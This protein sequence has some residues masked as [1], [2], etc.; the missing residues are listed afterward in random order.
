MYS[1]RNSETNDSEIYLVA[2]EI[3]ELRKM[4]DKSNLLYEKLEDK[5]N[6]M[7][8]EELLLGR[9]ISSLRNQHE[10]LQKDFGKEFLFGTTLPGIE[11]QG[12]KIQVGTIEKLSERFGL[13]TQ[14]FESL[15]LIPEASDDEFDAYI[16]WLD[17]VERDNKSGF[18]KQAKNLAKKL[19]DEL[20]L[21]RTKKLYQYLNDKIECI[22]SVEVNE[23]DY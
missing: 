12:R 23:I 6:K 16:T 4:Y 8:Q 1:V 9:K 19:V 5:G 21:E 18:T 20:D 17:D 10:Y 3:N 15:E 22:L 13:S 2:D 7:K 14:Y 11:T